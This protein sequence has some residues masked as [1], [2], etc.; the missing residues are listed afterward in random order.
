MTSTSSPVADSAANYSR[1]IALTFVAM[2][3]FGVQDA[4]A[5]IIVQ[6]YSPFQISMMRFWAFAA[7]SLF[8]VSRQAPLRRAF[9]SAV[10]RL[11]IFRAT[12]LIADIWMFAF[13]VKTV[14]LGELATISLIYPLLVTVLAVVF[15]GERVGVFRIAAVVVGFCGALLIVRPGGLPMDWGVLFAVLSA[16]AYA[17]YII[18]TRKVA[19]VDSTATSM[20]Y[21][22]ATGLVMTSAVG[23]FFWQPMDW[24]GV[25]LVAVVMATM[26]GAH[27]L[28]MEALKH[29]PASV[30][31]PFSY[32][33]L[34]WAIVLSF[35]VF[36][37]LIDFISFV[38]ATIVAGAG[39][40]VW[41]RERQ[42]KVPV[43]PAIPPTTP[44]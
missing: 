23:V 6:D 27:T 18:C 11:Q 26:I 24:R 25:G 29:A 39:L 15:L 10:P 13:A 40:V 7:V 35:V 17:G 37:H 28:M 5:K 32:F 36:G 14:P 41:V 19:V 2:L 31:Q 43:P 1:G 12:L 30:L 22:G 42:R 33:G 16:V 38:G 44:G 3:I 20:V 4:V 34:P 9:Q 21:V 8:F